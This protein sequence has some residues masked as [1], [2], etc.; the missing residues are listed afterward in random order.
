MAELFE[1]QAM[2]ILGVSMPFC[3]SI[4]VGFLC[5]WASF[6]IFPRGFWGSLDEEAVAAEGCDVKDKVGAEEKDE[7]GNRECNDGVHGEQINWRNV[8]NEVSARKRSSCNS[9]P[10][11]GE[12]ESSPSV[13]VAKG[14]GSSGNG[15]LSGVRGFVPPSP[16]R[17]RKREEATCS[18]PISLSSPPPPSHTPC[19]T[20]LS[21]PSSSSCNTHTFPIPCLNHPLEMYSKT[22]AFSRPIYA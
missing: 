3:I 14:M 10:R 19:P 22:C 8:I 20:S 5:G 16:S 2:R 9:I 1:E 18:Q 7:K 21:L 11:E 13:S 15:A 17:E 6:L 4:L 12:N